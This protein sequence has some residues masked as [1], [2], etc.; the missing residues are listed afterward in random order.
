MSRHI[1]GAARRR[2]GSGASPMAGNPAPHG[3]GGGSAQ[4]YDFVAK[5]RSGD[6]VSRPSEDE[7]RPDA[8]PARPE[9]SR[10]GGPRKRPWRPGLCPRSRQRQAELCLR[11]GGRDYACGTG[12]GAACPGPAGARD[13]IGPAAARPGRRRAAADG[14]APRAA[15]PRYRHRRGSRRGCAARGGRPPGRRA[16][17][18]RCRCRNG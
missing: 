18:S 6:P 13:A 4:R 3:S 7:N 16:P 10:Q 12:D 2:P 1:S 14:A 11:D 8:A 15:Q 5:K 17:T 9:T